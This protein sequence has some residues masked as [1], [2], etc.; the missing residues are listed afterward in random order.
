MPPCSYIN[1]GCGHHFHPE[2][3]NVDFSCTGE[4]V[5]SY[6]LRKGIPFPDESFTVVYTSHVLEHF[7]KTDA[8]I[9]LA[10][11][12]RIM[13]PQGIIRVAVPDLEQIARLYL[14]SLEKADQGDT[15]WAANYEWMML[16]MYD[17]V[18][19]NQSGGE[20]AKYLA[21]DTI[22]NQNFVI[23]RIG[24]EG[25]QIIDTLRHQNYDVN[26][27][28]KYPEVTP[29]QI[30]TFRQSGEP[31]QWMYDRYSLRCLLGKSGFQNIDI[32][33]PHESRIPSFHRYHLDV[34]PNGRVRKPDSLFIE[35]TKFSGLLK[36]DIAVPSKMTPVCF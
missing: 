8:P 3:V 10:E 30:G 1:L 35:A 7:S 25:E 16:E 11:C 29:L 34:M 12:Y 26:N 23:G 31:H 33:Q 6:D 21:K 14:E 24:V 15:L 17:Q 20:M 4:G 18:V 28:K 32:C 9:F 19:R 22:P 36:Q 2:W 5:I 27:F 13:K